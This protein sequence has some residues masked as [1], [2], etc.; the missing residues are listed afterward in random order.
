MEVCQVLVVYKDLDREWGAIEGMSTRLQGMNDDKEFTVINVIV[1][2]SWY[3]RLR[4]VGV[5]MPVTIRVSLEKNHACHMHDFC[6][7]QLHQ[8]Q[9]NY[10]KLQSTFTQE[11]PWSFQ[12]SVH[13]LFYPSSLCSLYL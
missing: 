1:L 5:G 11:A 4:E 12:S 13:I 10:H 6:Y 8:L 3:E 9:T 2:F 7:V